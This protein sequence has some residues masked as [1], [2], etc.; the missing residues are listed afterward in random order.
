MVMGPSGCG[1]ST[2]APLLARALL[3][4][5][6]EGDDLHPPANRER[7][8]RGQALTDDDRA[9]FLNA[10]A[11]RLAREPRSVVSCSA[12]KRSYRDQLRAGVPDLV[13][14]HPAVPFAELARRVS[15]RSSHFMPASLLASQLAALE[16]LMAD[17]AGFTVDGAMEPAEQVLAVLDYL[18]VIAWSA[19]TVQPSNQ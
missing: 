2:I 18:P 5:F 7:M 16:P 4:T 17:E 11:E 9:P 14:I 1:K 3:L 19:G 12:L 15:E 10:V 6:V 8:A 13:F